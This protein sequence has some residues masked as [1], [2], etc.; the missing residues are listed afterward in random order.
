MGEQVKLGPLEVLLMNDQIRLNLLKEARSKS[1]MPL[2]FW[3]EFTEGMDQSLL[4]ILVGRSAVFP[5]YKKSSVSL[6]A[7]HSFF[8]AISERSRCPFSKGP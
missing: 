3:D 8:A 7:L 6:C 1:G 2:D 5:K 4:E